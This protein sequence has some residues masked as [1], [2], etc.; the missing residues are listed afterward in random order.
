MVRWR[1]VGGNA[2]QRCREK[3]SREE[4]D[5]ANCEICWGD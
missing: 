2:Q 4:Q 5:T 1:L 3:V